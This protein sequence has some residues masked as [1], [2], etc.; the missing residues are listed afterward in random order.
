MSAVNGSE[1]APAMTQE[2]FLAFAQA[3]P[4]LVAQAV[5]KSDDPV[6]KQYQLPTVQSKA[7]LDSFIE[8]NSVKGSTLRLTVQD[9]LSM[10]RLLGKISP[11]FYLTP[12]QKEVH[13]LLRDEYAKGVAGQPFKVCDDMSLTEEQVK[14]LPI[15]AGVDSKLFKRLYPTNWS[16]QYSLRHGN[17]KMIDSDTFAIMTELFS[18]LR[19]A[20]YTY[21]N[22]RGEEVLDLGSIGYGA[23]E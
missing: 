14:A 20:G 22:G 21:V 19:G 17:Q 1:K 9:A 23:D 5:A 11:W 2:E 10:Q 8:V 12:E 7:P 18:L 3:N 4:E 16:R 6:L 15:Q 13:A